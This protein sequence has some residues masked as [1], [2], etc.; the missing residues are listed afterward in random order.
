[1]DRH[2]VAAELEPMLIELTDLALTA[3]QAHWNLTGPNFRSIHLQL[4]DLATDARSWSDRVAER[5]VAL[6]V[7]ADARLETVADGL[8]KHRWMF[9]AQQ[10]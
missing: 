6:G 5:I 1:M 10:A 2:A 3:K 8:E 9:S 7:A 4:D